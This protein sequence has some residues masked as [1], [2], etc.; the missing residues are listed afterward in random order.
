MRTLAARFGGLRSGVGVVVEALDIEGIFQAGE[1]S[2]SASRYATGTPVQSISV[3]SVYARE[4]RKSDQTSLAAHTQHMR[5]EKCQFR[6][7]KCQLYVALARSPGDVQHEHLV[8]LRGVAVVDHLH[9][10]TP[11]TPVKGY[12]MPDIILYIIYPFTGCG[13]PL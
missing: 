10:Y 12:T 8:P 2:A 7:E 13:P 1:R 6:T 4:K 11:R 9:L 5:T 3:G